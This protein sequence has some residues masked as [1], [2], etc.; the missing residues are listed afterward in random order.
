MGFSYARVDISTMCTTLKYGRENLP[1]TC[2]LN[3]LI[4][5]VGRKS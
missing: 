3:T 5:T 2:V 1:L 4:H